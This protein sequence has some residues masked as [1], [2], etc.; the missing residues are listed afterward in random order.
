MLADMVATKP[1]RKRRWFRYSLGALLVLA[2]VCAV[3]CGWVVLKMRQAEQQR[4]SAAAIEKL[5][6]KIKWDER[7]S[8]Y[9]EWMRSVLGDAFF[10]SV[11][12]VDLSYERVAD[13]DLGSVEDFD[14]LQELSLDATQ[15]TDVGLQ[16]LKGLRHVKRLSLDSTRVTGAGLEH[17]RGLSQLQAL[18]LES[19]YVTNAGLEHLKALTQ[20]RTLSLR[21]TEV[22]DEGAEKLRQALPKCAIEAMQK[23]EIFN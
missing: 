22:T 12:K 4:Q 5:G 11:L 6:G 9:P 16:H 1:K 21:Y 19:T 13:M 10:N 15:V 23:V 18:S 3:P 7:A 20:L 8:R 2:I 14:Q 17:L